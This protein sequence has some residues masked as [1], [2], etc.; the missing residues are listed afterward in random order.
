MAIHVMSRVEKK[1]KINTHTYH[2]IIEAIAPHTTLDAYNEKTDFYT[3]SNI[4]YDTPDS[5][6]IRLSLSKPE[7]KEKIRL[8]TYGVPNENDKVYL[9]IKKKYRKMVNKRR[10]S[11][12]LQD[13]YAFMQTK[14]PP[15]NVHQTQI[16]NELAFALDRYNPVPKVYLSYD[17]RA[18]FGEN[19]LRITFD[20]NIR[21][22][23]HDLRLELGDYGTPLLG[24]DTWLMEIKAESAFP[25]W[26]TRLLAQHN[27][28]P[29]S[30][31]KYGTEYKQFLAKGREDECLTPSLQPYL[32]QA[33]LPLLGKEPAL[34][35]A[36]H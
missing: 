17:R 16:V 9:E 27:V 13:A 35:L 25:M 24:G 33:H 26:L 18:Y 34:R 23:R 20:T 4:Y 12:S 29:N 15:I 6:L 2:Q 8:R 10:A 7:Y 5:D 21:T 22:R 31:S 14:T 3:V 28:F 1:Y 11:F 19:G 32:I 30:F 36:Q